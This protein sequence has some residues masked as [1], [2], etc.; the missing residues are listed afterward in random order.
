MFKLHRH[1]SDRLVER[2][3]FKFSNFR[4][5][6]IPKGWDKIFISVV[7]VDSGKS[8]AKTSRAVVR[9]G[10]CHWPDS[11]S[12]FISF[13]QDVTTK[14]I[15]ECQYRFVV[16]MGST[17]TTILG[18][19]TLNLADYLSSGDS[20][21]FSSQ[22][23]KCNFTT[24]L[25]PFVLCRGAKSAKDGS[26]YHEELN[27]SNDSK[28]DGSATPDE[29][30]TRDASLSASE[31]HCSSN[32]GDISIDR[33]TFSPQNTNL[34]YVG[35]HMGRQ[36]S[37]GSFVSNNS[38]FSKPNGISQLASPLGSNKDLLEAAEE[39]IEELR[40]EA[41][42]WERHSRKVKV[43]M[44]NLK[45]DYAE[46]AKQLDEVQMELSSS[47][48]ERDL[49][50][51]EVDQLKSSL[52]ESRASAGETF[53]TP[54]YDD[55]ASPKYEE[56]V[57]SHKELED[58]LQFQKES[59][60]NLTLQLKK[61]Q[62]VNVELLAVIQELEEAVEAQRLEFSRIK[63]V[64]HMII[65]KDKEI[66]ALKEKLAQ[67]VNRPSG[68]G[69]NSDRNQSNSDLERENEAL[70]AKIHELERDCAELT[71]ENLELLYK[72]NDLG[73]GDITKIPRRDATE[74]SQLNDFEIKCAELEIKL[75]GFREEN[76]KLLT[77]L[78][79]SEEQMIEKN[80]ELY[81]LRERLAFGN[82]SFSEK[83]EEIKSETTDSLKEEIEILTHSNTELEKRNGE[84]E[85]M[86]EILHNER[87]NNS[88]SLEEVKRD[89]DSHVASNKGLERKS[90]ELELA[91]KEVELQ[92]TELE[93][94]NVQ[95]SERISGLEAQSRYLKDEQESNR[96]ELEDSRSL[97]QELKQKLVKQQAEVNQAKL[98]Q[99]DKL[100][101]ASE[102]FLQA[103]E[104][105][106]ALRRSNAKVQSTAEGLI[107]ECSSL[108]SL[109]TT[110]RKQKVHL[111]ETVTRLE[112]QLEE[113][114]KK[115]VEFSRRAENLEG[116]LLSLQ[117]DVSS[118]EQTMLSEVERLF[119]EHKEQEEKINRTHQMFSKLEIEK[120]VEVES[121]H[122]EIEALTSRI[123]STDNEQERMQ[124]D[125][126]PEV[127]NLR[128]DKGKLESSLTAANL[129]IKTYESELETLKRESKNKVQGLVDLLN[130]SKQ[131]E[132]MLMADIDHM[133][134]LVETT[135]S[136]E[137]NSNR[138]LNELEV[139]LKSTNYEKRQ[140]L[141]E[142][143]DLKS[144]VQK[145]TQLQ[146]EILHLKG[147]IDENK[148]E[149]EKLEEKLK[150]V[151]DEYE[152]L[153]R[154]NES[155]TER[156]GSMEKAL[157]TGEDAKRSKTVLEAKLVRLQSDLS[158]KDAAGAVEVELR[159]EMNRMKRSNNEYQRRIQSL[160]QEKEDLLRSQ[161]CA[162]GEDINKP[163]E[164]RGIMHRESDGKIAALEAELKDMKERYSNMSLQYAQ[165]EADREEL[166][167]K[168]KA[169]KPTSKGWFS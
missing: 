136:N 36:D 78:H 47:S 43:E 130:A 70:K 141:E 26:S 95:L 148:F 122:R 99:K 19:I 98:E 158:L 124:L 113:S 68:P 132:A 37:T 150:S 108:Q 118:K 75:Q 21:V 169:T 66:A 164:D 38:P 59:N 154:E 10:T 17:R 11:M 14:E 23:K 5:A 168:L 80:K 156:V 16:L 147:L 127:S 163:A 153:R 152:E 111:H 109:N 112:L 77:R 105:V 9:N 24:T 13:Y 139:R 22:L 60:A 146:E 51:L 86:I 103:Q 116:K 100:Q 32:S 58:E 138:R 67:V 3:E 142:I 123:S 87:S 6:Q 15:E 117:I 12:E 119:E 104:E 48:A 155:L 110:L 53:G 30:G 93:Q 18:E 134:S 157:N 31:S 56:M 84:L 8:I 55:V 137:E 39:T 166:V 83:L 7:C 133:R 102:K 27:A 159:N 165:V 106:E 52:E 41:K 42:M 62:E 135:R 33:T 81:E 35:S 115:C 44:E 76:D 94:E 1:K 85:E 128:A 162:H 151:S 140:I 160:E 131:S 63:D 97:I 57:N 92:I 49:L 69:A 126:L 29:L 114:Q 121:L 61:T 54:K 4:A 79:K 91:N 167:L 46:K 72:M 74:I 71:E 25:Q 125:T 2:I 101:E 149:K 129:Q 65:K 28:S 64:E 34:S 20:S 90:K 73:N 145:I 89:I 50:K 45:K 143:S 88:A 40:D 120:G 144:Q 82:A 161:G 96:S 107:E